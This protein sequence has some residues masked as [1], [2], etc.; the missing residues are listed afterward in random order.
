MQMNQITRLY[1]P[2]H[3]IDKIVVSYGETEVVTITGDISI[4]SDPVFN[5]SF[6]PDGPGPMKV[7]VSDTEGG[8]WEQTFE[9]TTPS[10]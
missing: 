3:Y 5:F 8:R 4:S 10:N 1:R 2:A 6:V 9:T 7:V